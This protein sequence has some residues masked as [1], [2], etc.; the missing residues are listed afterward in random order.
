MG[1][2]LAEDCVYLQYSVS[3]VLSLLLGLPETLFVILLECG[4]FSSLDHMRCWLDSCVRNLSVL[5]YDCFGHV[6]VLS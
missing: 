3:A 4:C 1:P 6:V 2:E 5:F